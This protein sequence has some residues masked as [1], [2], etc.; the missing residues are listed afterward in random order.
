MPKIHTLKKLNHSAAQMFALVA[1]V[2][3]YP[4][5]VPFCT[6]LHITGQGEANGVPYIDAVMQVEYKVL[7]ERFTS[8][9]FLYEAERR[10]EVQFLSGPMKALSNIW[11]FT[12][13][14]DDACT[15]DFTL[16]YEFKNPLLA[17]AMNAAFQAVFGTFVRSFERYADARFSAKRI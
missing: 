16:N 8:R 4:Q 1:D 14:G 11:V 13:H 7:R 3:R 12:P 9:V 17:M 15:V 6:N 10:I 2:E 5:F